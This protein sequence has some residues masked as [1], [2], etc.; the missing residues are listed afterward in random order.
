MNDVNLAMELETPLFRPGVGGRDGWVKHGRPDRSVRVGAEDGGGRGN[1]SSMVG[2]DD[3]GGPPRD[4]GRER[5]GETD[6][7]GP[8]SPGGSSLVAFGVLRRL[9]KGPVHTLDL[10]PGGRDGGHSG[11]EGAPA[12]AGGLLWALGP[13]PRFAV[14]YRRG[15]G[16]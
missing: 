15:Y 10:G 7:P 9:D 12:A 1:G 11:H 13:D 16:R 3:R 8:S 2:A 4:G 14:D 5:K 6:Y